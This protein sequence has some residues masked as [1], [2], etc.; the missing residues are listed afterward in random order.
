MND[1]PIKDPDMHGEPSSPSLSIGDIAW[2]GLNA[3]ASLRLTVVTFAVALLLVFFGTMAQTSE[4]IW[5]VV[6]KYFRSTY[7]WVPFQL[8]ATFFQKFFDLSKNTKWGGSFPFPG[9]WLIGS[10]MMANLLAAHV[11]RFRWKWKRIGI[12]LIH[13]G[14]VALMLG[15]L[16]T[17][18]YAVE[19]KMYLQKDESTNYLN[20]S[21]SVELAFHRMDGDEK[22]ETV[23]PKSMLKKG[24]IVRDS[25]LP[26]DVEILDYH[27]NSM[28][29]PIDGD[30]DV[31]GTLIFIVNPSQEQGQRDNTS[32]TRFMTEP[33]PEAIGV[34]SAAEDAPA[35]KVRL[36]VKDTPDPIG[37]YFVSLWHDRNF[38]MR[39]VIAVPFDF[40]VDGKSYRMELRNRRIYKPFTFQ[41]TNFEHKKYPGTETSKDFVSTVNLND[42]EKNVSREG[43]RIWMNHPLRYRGETYYQ[44]QFFFDDS[45][46]VLQV[47]NNPGWLLPYA[48]CALV[49]LGMILHF[50]ITLSTFL[51]RRKKI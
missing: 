11:L 16:I 7:V 31:P 8:L 2:M 44:N 15:E 5:T 41:L 30:K 17:G 4:G 50:G 42:P 25:R 36:R 18:M 6:D 39:R 20:D 27:K 23:I 49:A 38:S 19:S 43:I 3:L 37:T 9:G 13:S 40:V 28:P 22:T 10:I 51:K 14:F 12:I 45:G 34:K 21:L 32:G 48:S 47:V 24:E 35:V 1:T 29:R 26:V 46:T 33:A